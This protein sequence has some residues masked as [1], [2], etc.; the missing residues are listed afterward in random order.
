MTGTQRLGHRQTV[1]VNET[2]PKKEQ[3]TDQSAVLFNQN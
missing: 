3:P 2:E 1:K